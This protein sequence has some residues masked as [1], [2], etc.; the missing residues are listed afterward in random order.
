MELSTCVLSG[1]E[2]LLFPIT[3]NPVSIEGSATRK[4]IALSIAN[5]LFS[6][7]PFANQNNTFLANVDTCGSKSNSSCVAFYGG[8]YDPPDSVVITGDPAAWNGT[9]GEVGPG[10]GYRDLL[11]NDLLRIGPFEIPGFP[12]GTYESDSGG[13]TDPSS[14]GIGVNSSFL[15]AALN[16]SM[17]GTKQWSLWPGDLRNNID[18]LLVIGGYDEDR[19]AGEFTSFD[20]NEQLGVGP[21]VEITGMDWESSTGNITNLMP[22]N[23]RSMRATLEPAYHWLEMPNESYLKF[24][25]ATNST[26]YNETSG[27]YQYYQWPEGNLTITLSNGLRTTIP[28][29][30]LFEYPTYFNDRGYLE[31]LNKTYLHTSVTWTG[32][33]DDLNSVAYPL[34][35]GQPF[36]TQKLLVT[37]WDGGT[38]YLA[39]AIRTDLGPGARSLKP[40]CTGGVSPSATPTTLPPLPSAT[41]NSD[42]GKGSDDDGEPNNSTNVGAIA[43]GVVGGVAGLAIIGI[44]AFCLVRRRKKQRRVSEGQQQQYFPEVAEAPYRNELSSPP[45]KYISGGVYEADNAT[46]PDPSQRY[47][48]SLAQTGGTQNPS[49]PRSELGTTSP[50]PWDG[51]HASGRAGLATEMSTRQHGMLSGNKFSATSGPLEMPENYDERGR[52]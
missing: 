24:A 15:E 1:V 32:P 31:V 7:D 37:D 10:D 52:A 12:F 19:V 8:L 47:A 36:M 17:I 45:P 5:Q 40:L 46:T 4:G 49:S 39:D 13:W 27:F 33:L 28:Q 29:T 38:F 23:T 9:P 30:D 25:A 21:Y 11:F 43:G 3:N 44:L 48:S 22:N 41:S 50:S 2:P 14:L 20:T 6:V 35:L 26:F 16:G 51:E 34:W 18:G 42:N